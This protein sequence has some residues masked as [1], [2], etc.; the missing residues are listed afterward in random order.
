MGAISAGQSGS[1]QPCLNMC[2]DALSGLL[3]I[4]ENNA[5]AVTTGT[6]ESGPKMTTARPQGDERLD[7]F[8]Q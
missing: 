5:A 6:D 4:A 3:L 2:L 1:R 7:S 8:T